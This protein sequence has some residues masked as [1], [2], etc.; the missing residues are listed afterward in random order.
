MDAKILDTITD[1]R[2]IIVA[3]CLVIVAAI[4]YRSFHHKPSLPKQTIKVTPAV[5]I[6]MCNFFWHLGSQGNQPGMDI[7]GEFIV[8]NITN[9]PIK[10]VGAK[11]KKSKVMGEVLMSSNGNILLPGHAINVRVWFW[12]IPPLLKNKKESFIDKIALVDQ[13]GNSHW[14]DKIEFKSTAC[15]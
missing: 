10:L 4:K 7:R 12:I 2:K 8:T 5:A 3:V 1:F 13:C 9:Q 6:G 15:P 11:I 14:T